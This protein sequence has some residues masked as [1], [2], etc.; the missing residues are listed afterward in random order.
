MDETLIQLIEQIDKRLSNIEA[1]QCDMSK[2]LDNHIVHIAADIGVMRTDIDWLKRLVKSNDNFL[3]RNDGGKESKDDIKTQTD[4]DWL[5]RFFFIGISA[6][7]TSIASLI[8][9]LINA[10]LR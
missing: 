1:A 3:S 6:I 10:F 9:T 7:V 8:I 5:K 4:V 2:K